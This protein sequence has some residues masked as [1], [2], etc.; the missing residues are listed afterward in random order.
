MVS[1]CNLLFFN[2]AQGSFVA[3]CSAG[4]ACTRPCCGCRQECGGA[5]EVCTCR[6]H[7][8]TNPHPLLPQIPRAQWAR[9]ARRIGY[10]PM[11]IWGWCFS[12][13]PK[14]AS[15]FG[16]RLCC[17]LCRFLC[18]PSRGP[19][20]HPQSWDWRCSCIQHA[21]ADAL[22]CAKLRRRLGSWLLP[23]WFARFPMPTQCPPFGQPP[24]KLLLH[25]S[26]LHPV[27]PPARCRCTLWWAS[28]SQCPRWSSPARSR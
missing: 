4:L 21:Q 13:M 10:V 16:C 8:F 6:L 27:L 3:R 24:A 26:P 18:R 9:L 12:F 5:F 7:H 19:P 23:W 15:G 22:M 20:A 25:A 14:Q 17:C 28:P 11:I 2:G 1:F